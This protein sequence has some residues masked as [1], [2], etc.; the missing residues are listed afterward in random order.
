MSV[1]N[2]V[3]GANRNPF[4]YEKVEQINRDVVTPWLDIGEIR[5]QINL[6]GDTS[7]DD[8]ISGLE[9][10]VRNFIEDYLGMTIFPASYRVYYN[11]N[12][13]YGTPLSLD[14]PIVSQNF[15]PSQPGVS[16]NAV[17]YWNSSNVLMTV[18]PSDYFYDQSGNKI[19]INSLPT[20]ISTQ[21]TSPVFCEYTTASNP[22]SAYP[23]IK[24]AGM[25]LL[26]HWYNTRSSATEKIMREI[27]F[28]FHAMLRPYKPLVL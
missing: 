25:L 16:V 14:L 7:Q 9:L 19:I 15:Y 21:R 3:I 23:V 1:E 24:Q 18:A 8:Y 2:I 5:D 27:P 10:A 26:T 22:L 12:S 28:G 11:A 13:L 6:Y 4:N 17:K 20:N